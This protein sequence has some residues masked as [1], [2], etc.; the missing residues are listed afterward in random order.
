MRH[1]AN[2]WLPWF[3]TFKGDVFRQ[4]KLLGVTQRGVQTV[5]ATRAVSD[6]DVMFREF[7]DTSGDLCF[8][9]RSWDAPAQEAE[10]RIVFEPVQT[11]VAGRRFTGFKYW[12]EYE[13]AE[14][15][16]HRLFDR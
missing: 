2:R 13:S 5:V 10:L 1:P 6:P 8:R 3:D 16:I 7:R 9:D 11:A 15:M 14:V 12:Y 4:F